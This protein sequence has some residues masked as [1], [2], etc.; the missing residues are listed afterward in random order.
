[1]QPRAPI[2]RTMIIRINAIGRTTRNVSRASDVSNITSFSWVSIEPQLG[3]ASLLASS[4][5]AQTWF[6]LH[7]SF[8][9]I[10][11][12]SPWWLL[13]KGVFTSPVALRVYQVIVTNLWRVLW[14][15]C[16][17]GPRRDS[18]LSSPCVW[19]WEA[20][21]KVW[22]ELPIKLASKSCGSTFHASLIEML[23]CLQVLIV[24]VV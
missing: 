21:Y 13:L 22:R 20:T 14:P 1:M 8:I 24:F 19:A 11:P 4:W 3:N 9:H 12:N 6:V 5:D 10:V 16:P 18:D 17:P 15:I 2:S 7:A 23:V